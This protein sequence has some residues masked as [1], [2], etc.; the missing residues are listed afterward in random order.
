MKIDV[1]RFFRPLRV[2]VAPVMA[3]GTSL[4][5]AYLVGESLKYS[6]PNWMLPVFIP[7]SCFL[8]VLETVVVRRAY[9]KGLFSWTPGRLLASFLIAIAILLALHVA[10][11]K[12]VKI[13]ETEVTVITSWSRNFPN[14]Q[15][16]QC[17]E[18]FSF[19]GL[20]RCWNYRWVVE[21][22]MALAYLTTLAGL[23]ALVGVLA[24]REPLLPN[25]NSNLWVRVE[26]APNDAYR[27]SAR[28]DAGS[29]SSW[30]FRLPETLRNV[31]GFTR[32]LE[33]TVRG[34]PLLE[35]VQESPKV[36]GRALFDAVFQG[37]VRAALYAAIQNSAETERDSGGFRIRL[38]LQHAPELA[39]LPWEYLYDEENYA[40][41]AQSRATPIVRS[42]ESLR[43]FRPLR[44][45]PPLTL[46][47]VTAQPEGWDRLGVD[48]ELHHIEEALEPL[49]GSIVVEKLQH[50]TWEALTER[51]RDEENPIH[52]LHFIGH[53]GHTD[54]GEGA[55]VFEGATGEK[56]LTTGDSLAS[57]L[58]D[59]GSI[60]LAVLNA[61]EGARATESRALAGVAQRLLVS[62][63][64]PA[65]VA[66]QT[67]IT[68]STARIFARWFYDALAYGYP[69]DVA[70]S[71]VRK[72]LS[73]QG[74]QEWGTP[75]LYLHAP[76]ATLFEVKGR[77]PKDWEE[78]LEKD[79]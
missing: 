57:A 10:F 1:G 12:T 29:G 23:G 8:A 6:L 60:R 72:L 39:V 58:K 7:V 44:V 46:L 65:V 26:P 38:N 54:D 59:H 25:G 71:E 43:P 49:K 32:A 76:D 16:H 21:L 75:V 22:A 20:G 67:A 9:A 17:I 4:V 62:G 69:L 51:L 27:V 15:L 48:K 66:M 61:C 2:T 37:N 78:R 36:F 18:R 19:A 63:D 47:I 74:N 68:D 13:G 64:L 52:V 31:K 3:F 53:G 11:V 35:K 33:G 42:V 28:D 24:R 5:L 14:L 79:S 40:F 55:L 34:N 41:L 56:V 70:L 77:R 30:T 73:G 50:A 45:K